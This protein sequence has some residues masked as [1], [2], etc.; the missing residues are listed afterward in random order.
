MSEGSTV[1][2][3]RTQSQIHAADH[4]SAAAL[5][6][7]CHRAFLAGADTA[8]VPINRGL[9]ASVDLTL[10]DTTEVSRPTRVVA[11]PE[12]RPA[13]PKSL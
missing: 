9:S 5:T 8:S 10:V 13:T 4:S 2:N 11:G 1:A 6:K 12:L 3:S 7:G